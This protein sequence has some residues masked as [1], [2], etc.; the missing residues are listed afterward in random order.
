MF[1]DASGKDLPYIAS[2]S[3]KSEK[4][5]SITYKIVTINVLKVLS[6]HRRDDVNKIM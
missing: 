3:F 6:T 2:F 1:L 5:L 4:Q